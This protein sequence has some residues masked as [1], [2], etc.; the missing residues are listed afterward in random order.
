[1]IDQVE[2]AFLEE[3][4]RRENGHFWTLVSKYLSTFTSL[5]TFV[6]SLLHVPPNTRSMI[7]GKIIGRFENLETLVFS[8]ILGCNMGNVLQLC[9]LPNFEVF[10]C[11]YR[12]W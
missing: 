6:L 9:L 1:M 11:G 5:K 7:L 2:C 4:I 3:P 12:D 8:R 10:S